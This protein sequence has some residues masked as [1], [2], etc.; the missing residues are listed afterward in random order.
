MTK[1]ESEKLVVEDFGTASAFMAVIP[2]T[3]YETAKCFVVFYQS[4]EYIE[5]GS[6]GSELVGHGPVLVDKKTKKLY[7]T[8]SARLAESYVA[9]YEKYGDPFMGEDIF[10]LVIERPINTELNRLDA[11]KILKDLTGKGTA[12]AHDTLKRLEN[13]GTISMSYDFYSSEKEGLEAVGFK[14][15]Q[16]AETV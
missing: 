16:L 13:G 5:T 1:E 14:V 8:G 3:T 7:H 12:E 9:S 4:K 6:L 15:T 2:N 10:S 11:L